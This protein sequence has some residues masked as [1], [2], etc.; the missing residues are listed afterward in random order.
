MAFLDLG[1]DE[2]RG[3][4]DD[5]DVDNDDDDVDNDDGT[6]TLRGGVTDFFAAFFFALLGV[7]RGGERRFDDGPPWTE[8]SAD[9]LG[10]GSKAQ[11]RR[12]LL[13]DLVLCSHRARTHDGVRRRSR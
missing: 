10:S 1:A 3:E 13:P 9:S 12:H 4:N 11:H 6:T 5:D 8:H 2:G 7:V